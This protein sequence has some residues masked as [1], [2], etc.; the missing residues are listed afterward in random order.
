MTLR[1]CSVMDV[2]FAFF[3]SS[4]ATH[5]RPR[6]G[7]RLAADQ[8]PRYCFTSFVQAFGCS[9]ESSSR[10][11]KFAE[12]VTDSGRLLLHL[13]KASCE[14]SLNGSQ[15]LDQRRV[16]VV[17]STVPG[18]DDEVRL[19]LTVQRLQCFNQVLTVVHAHSKAISLELEPACSSCCCWML[20]LLRR[21][22]HSAHDRTSVDAQTF[23][24]GE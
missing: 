21:A 1:T 24:A 15:S 11:R 10:Q 12:N 6:L 17:V 23:P 5:G 22:A 3:A 19:V 7:S 18:I 14:T 13:G 16:A 20:S 8:L 2:L 4:S 9:L